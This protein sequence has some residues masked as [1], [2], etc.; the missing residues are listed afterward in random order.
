MYTYYRSSGNKA[1]AVTYFVVM[2]TMMNVL[3]LNLFLAI[4]LDS[5]AAKASDED[6]LKEEE[7]EEVDEDIGPVYI[8]L[9]LIKYRVVKCCCCK[10][11]EMEG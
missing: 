1:F 10:K 8:C 7:E 4:L 2:Y 6:I 3:L 5:Y 9:H 11:K